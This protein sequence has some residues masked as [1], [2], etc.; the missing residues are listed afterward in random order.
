MWICYYRLQ[1]IKRIWLRSIQTPTL[2]NPGQGFLIRGVQ[3]QKL[4]FHERSMPP[5]CGIPHGLLKLVG[6]RWR[7]LPQS[8]SLNRDSGDL[9]T[10]SCG[11]DGTGSNRRKASLFSRPPL[12]TMLQLVHH[13]HANKHGRC[14][15]TVLSRAAMCT[16]NSSSEP[17]INT[18]GLQRRRDRQSNVY[19]KLN[20]Y[21]TLYYMIHQPR[22][23]WGSDLWRPLAQQTFESKG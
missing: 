2:C 5:R 9:A 8:K 7:L 21:L 18:D 10:S 19:P 15:G 3:A 20:Q 6:S 11:G 14:M 23:R 1:L 16:S 4:L 13:L 22:I 17:L 12:R